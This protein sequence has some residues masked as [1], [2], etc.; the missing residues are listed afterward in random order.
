MPRPVTNWEK[1][2]DETRI[3]FDLDDDKLLHYGPRLSWSPLTKRVFV[4]GRTTLLHGEADLG[5]TE[6]Q[7][8]ALQK[9]LPNYRLA[10][11][12]ASSID[13]TISVG[14]AVSAPHSAKLGLIESLPF[15]K[16][17]F[18]AAISHED[19]AFAEIVARLEDAWKDRTLVRGS[20]DLRYSMTEVQGACRVAYS[21]AEVAAAL[22]DELVGS[23]WPLQAVAG[24]V[25]SALQKKQA[26]WIVSRV[27]PGFLND[28]MGVV[29]AFVHQ[30]IQRTF[31]RSSA[32]VVQFDSGESL[33][34]LEREDAG[35]LV[36]S[37]SW[38]L[39][40]ARDKQRTLSFF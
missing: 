32:P 24:G 27:P 40:V 25:A 19:P 6:A 38:K 36:G 34:G 37:F 12:V 10:P 13:Q 21:S 15:P 28:A 30:E 4:A 35:S 23:R 39:A 7:L 1:L 9:L 22:D 16:V 17:A 2:A 29:R 18:N 31:F 11:L 33:L 14:I 3:F 5:Y 20:L 26:N 8:G